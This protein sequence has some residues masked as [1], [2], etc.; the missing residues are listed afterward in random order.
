MKKILLI[1][2]DLLVREDAKEIMELSNYCVIIADNGKT[3]IAKAIAERPDLIV[4]N[5][6]LP[7][8]D[9]YGVLYAIQKNETTKHIPFIFLSTTFG[10]HDY[11]KAMDAGADDFIT[12]PFL[13]TELLNA[14]DSRFRK[15]DLLKI[16]SNPTLD[17]YNNSVTYD[18]A[19]NGNNVFQSI[20]SDRHV[21]RYKKKETIYTEGNHAIG[22]YYIIDGRVKTYRTNDIGKSLA[23]EVLNTG[24]IF[25]YIAL[26][27]GTTYKDNAVALDKT[28]VALISKNEFEILLNSNHKIAQ[29]FI[30]MLAN[31][32]SL[33]DE[34]LIGLAFDSLR[35]KVAVALVTLLNKFS[36]EKRAEQF[37]I[38]ISRDNLASIAGTATESLVRTLSDFKN[39]KLID[40]GKDGSLTIINEQKLS[41]LLY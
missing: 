18:L 5:I 33:K 4:C 15:A 24:D 2:D 11:R 10:K 35:K 38:N 17:K 13:A 20:V 21:S 3:G 12:K 9:G 7:I 30:Q 6:G 26:F 40:I 34:R 22:I 36:T 29:K 31:N 37:T 23:I 8:L 19:G 25:G 16:E 1:E 39:E 28:E 41:H 32:I 14:I 27:D